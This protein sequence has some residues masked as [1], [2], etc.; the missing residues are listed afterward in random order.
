[1]RNFLAFARAP[2]IWSVAILVL[3]A[4][5][6][7]IEPVIVPPPADCT[8]WLWCDSRYVGLVFNPAPEA[9]N[10]FAL[11]LIPATL[12]IFLAARIAARGPNAHAHWFMLG[13]A[14]GFLAAA[15]ATAFIPVHFFI[16]T[17][18]SY[19]PAV[20]HGSVQFAFFLG[21]LAS[22]PI[23]LITLIGALAWRRVKRG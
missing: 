15:I 3:Y 16:N 8:D 13:P 6:A 11:I 17:T 20:L 10:L 23:A 12:L 21:I 4:P 7:F 14:L 18:E 19:R 5:L 2:L 9:S 1:M 22:L